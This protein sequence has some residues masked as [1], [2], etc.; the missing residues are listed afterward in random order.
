MR[1]RLTLTVAIVAAL[2]L[3][4]GQV[5]A[6]ATVT[7]TSPADGSTISRSASP[8]F[9]M[10]GTA[11]FDTPSATTTRYFLRRAA[12][13]GSADPQ[14]RLSTVSGTDGGTGCGYIGGWNLLGTADEPGF[15]MD[16]PASDGVPLTLDASRAIT[17]RI[18]A[19]SYRGISGS[20]VG[21]AAGQATLTATLTGDGQ[22]LG[23]QSV[24]QTIVP[25]TPQYTY[26]FSFQPAASLDKK[27][28]TSLNLE[29]TMRGPGV[30]HGYIEK[31]G[32]SFVD[33]PAYT[34]SFDRRVQVQ[35]NNG[36]W[37]NATVNASLNGWNATLNT[38]GVGA[39]FI[40]ARAVQ[41]GAISSPVTQVLNVTA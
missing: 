27:D 14:M 25:T 15:A 29:L 11:S 10:A 22:V 23:S 35:V 17:A 34:A 16:F 41:G 28:F 2:G 20:P 30:G 21:I 18:V 3:L 26:D 39:H 1:T 13:G 24:T 38:P 9:S 7:I 19:S 36:S 6:T 4:A 33:V 31:S 5:S 40:R 8:Q 32:A 12:C 37:T